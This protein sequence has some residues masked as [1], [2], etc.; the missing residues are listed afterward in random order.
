MKFGDMDQ[1]GSESDDAPE[2]LSLSEGKKLTLE[3]KSEQADAIRCLKDERKR[4]L[5]KKQGSRENTKKKKSRPIPMSAFQKL[6]DNILDLLSDE[7]DENINEEVNKPASAKPRATITK[8]TDKTEKKTKGSVS[9]QGKDIE[10]HESENDSSNSDDSNNKDRFKNH[11]P[12]P[13][14]LRQET[15]KHKDINQ[16]VKDFLSNH[17]YGD[18]IKRVPAGSLPSK[19]GWKNAKPSLNF[20]PQ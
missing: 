15:A 12:K 13:V 8:N 10:E 6:P 14:V 2:T 5:R 11:D 9:P 16:S 18:R 3:R 20:V 19:K 17:L 4:K 1:G 7:V